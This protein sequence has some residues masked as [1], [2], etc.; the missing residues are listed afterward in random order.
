M[1]SNASGI[2]KKSLGSKITADRIA[3]MHGNGLGV[4]IND[5]VSP[6]GNALGTE[7]IV[8]ISVNYD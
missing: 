7:V 4:T 8:K 5:L 2:R 1:I 3:M 6:D